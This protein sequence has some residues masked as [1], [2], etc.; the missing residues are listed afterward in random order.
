MTSESNKHMLNYLAKPFIPKAM[1]TIEEELPMP[2]PPIEEEMPPAPI[3]VPISIWSTLKDGEYADRILEETDHEVTLKYF[4]QR[5]GMR[6]HL[7]SIGAYCFIKQKAGIRGFDYI[8]NITEIESLPR[9]NNI[10]VFKL[11]IKKTEPLWFRIKNDVCTH[12]GWRT[13]GSFEITHGIISHE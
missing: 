3:E 10:N 4:G 6:D 5:S 9:E 2:P 11:K 7:I 1:R 8:G 13:L 12:F